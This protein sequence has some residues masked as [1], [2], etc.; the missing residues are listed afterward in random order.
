MKRTLTAI[1]AAAALTAGSASAL[2]S[3]S[4]VINLSGEVD[5]VCELSP[6]GTT[7]YS[8]DMLD[9]NNQGALGILYSCNSPYTVSLQSLNGGMKHGESGGTVNIEYDI[10]AAG[11]DTGFVFGASQTNSA[12]MQASP[13]VI[14][15]NTDWQNIFFNGGVRA[16]SLE[17]SFE[18]LTEYA[19]AGTY[20]DE[21]TITLTATN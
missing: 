16:G 20:S 17:L 7:S 4:L 13:V 14:V 19:V 11:F 12:D 5:S 3:E 8:V 10:D 15:T 2:D 9:T 1:A 6:D 18:D 21:L